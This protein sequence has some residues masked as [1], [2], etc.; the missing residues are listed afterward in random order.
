MWDVSRQCD[1]DCLSTLL[2]CFWD[3]DAVVEWMDLRQA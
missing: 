2:Y 3:M 1:T